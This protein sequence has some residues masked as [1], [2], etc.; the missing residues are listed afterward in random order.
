MAAKCVL[1]PSLGHTAQ[2][3]IE[4]AQPLIVVPAV[5]PQNALHTQVISLPLMASKRMLGAV[6]LAINAADSSVV[7]EMLQNLERASSALIS[8]LTS[9][10]SPTQPVNAESLLK[11]QAELFRSASFEDSASALTSNLAV[12][13]GFDRVSIGLQEHEKVR[14]KALSHHA[15]FKKHQELLQMLAAAMEEAIDQQAS[16]LCPASLDNKPRIILAH[17]ELSRRTGMAICSVPLIHQQQVFGA[18]AFERS[19]NTPISA[20]DIARCESIAS[21]LGPVIQ[22]KYRA[23]LPWSTRTYETLKQNWDKC[24]KSGLTRLRV[25]TSSLL[26]LGLLGLMFP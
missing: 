26:L 4:R 6:A 2:A 20:D 16:I 11:L 3:A 22:L 17:N 19:K 9:M 13:L 21:L 10:G 15:E 24:T 18:I 25:M 12:M 8:V 14:V 7:Q 1:T 23:D 5:T